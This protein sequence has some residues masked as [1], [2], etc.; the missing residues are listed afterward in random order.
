MEEG[1]L[2]HEENPNQNVNQ[3]SD[4]TQLTLAEKR[5]IVDE[6]LTQLKEDDTMQRGMQSKIAAKFGVH[7]ST[8]CR[9]FND[10]IKQKQRGELIDVRNKKLGKVGPKF[11]HYSEEFRQ[12]WPL[13][14]R[15]TERSYAGYLKICHVTIHRL[16]KRGLLRTHTSCYHP[17]LTDNHKIERLRW[18]LAHLSLA[19][20]TEDP[21][22]NDMDHVI[23][24]DEKWFYMNPETRRFYL[25]PNEENPY[26]CEQSKRFKIKAMFMAMVGKPQYNTNGQMIHDGKYGIFGFVHEQRAKESS[27][28]RLAGTMELKALQSVTKDVIREMLINK[29]IPA[30]V[31][32]WPAHLSKEVVLQWDNARPHK[33]PTDPEFVAACTQNG[34]KIQMVYQPPQ[35]PDLNV[36]DLGLFTFM[37]SIQYQAFP[38]NVEELVKAVEDACNT[39]DP[40]SNKFTWV[41]LQSC[42]TEILKRMGDNNF[43]PPHMKKQR[44]EKMGILPKRLTMSPKIVAQAVNHLND[45]FRPVNQGQAKEE[46]QMEV[47]AD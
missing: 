36:L 4:R 47:D 39:F 27:K 18:V 11:K 7:K 28:N 15:T 33:I 14:L 34:F 25:L 35:S 23:H 45:R 40:T 5:G 46:D 37:Q 19:T 41:T 22:Y 38:K 30:I 3:Q 1:L 17:R 20:Q 24:I 12:S 13:R 21:M 44:L 6:I 10:V 32:K 8:V 43:T 31:E 29:V 26:R 9:L 16:K 2:Q 42:M